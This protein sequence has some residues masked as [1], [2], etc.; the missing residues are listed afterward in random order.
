MT[1]YFPPPNTPC[2]SQD[3]EKDCLESIAEAE[4]W[5]TV[6]KQVPKFSAILFLFLW[7]FCLYSL[8]LMMITASMYG[9]T[10]GK[11]ADWICFVLGLFCISVSVYL[12]IIYTRFIQLIHRK[13][14][15]WQNRFN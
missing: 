1:K 9:H 6:A 3:V 7:G 12:W 14:S 4:C 10:S 11:Y 15:I 13:A 5:Y 8:S 2:T